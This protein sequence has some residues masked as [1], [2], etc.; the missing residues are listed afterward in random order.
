[1][2][3]ADAS[4]AQIDPTDSDYASS[5]WDIGTPSLA[6]TVNEYVFENGIYRMPPLS[7]VNAE[8]NSKGAGTMRITARTRICYRPTRYNSLPSPSPVWPTSRPAD[9]G[10]P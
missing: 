2:L 10:R 5:G 7:N 1:V 4:R 8:F 9:R 3:S 6:S